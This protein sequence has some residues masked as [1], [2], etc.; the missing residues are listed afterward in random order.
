[1]EYQ[2]SRTCKDCGNIDMFPF[3]KV[4]AAFEL[5]NS[6]EIWNLACSKCSS[7]KCQ[8][9][10][11]NKPDIDKELLDLWGSDLTLFFMEQDEDL[12]IAD[13]DNLHLVLKV[14]DEKKYLK[15]KNSIL[16][17]S[18]CALLYD[19]SSSPEEYSEKENEERRKNAA[20][21]IP[22]LIKRKKEIVEFDEDIRDYI[23]IEIYPKI[24]LSN[25]V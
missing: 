6:A 17:Q 12:I 18:L 13:I 19:Y 5:Y 20:K 16:I 11:L 10:Y 3:T 8:S 7:Y 9:T 2:L 4:E 14:L 22:E 21:I 15:Q 1:M 25:K 23:K 24:E